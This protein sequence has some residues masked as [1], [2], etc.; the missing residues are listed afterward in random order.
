MTNILSVSHSPDIPPAHHLLAMMFGT[1]Q[2]QLIRVAAQLRIADL[3]KDGPKSIAT[4]A[5]ATCTDASALARVMRALTALGLV[6]ETETDQFTCTPVGELLRSDT[7][8]S[9]RSYTLLVGSEWLTRPWPNLLQGVQTGTS[10]F[11]QVFGAPLYEYLQYHPDAAAVFNDALTSISQQEA[12]ALREV[13]DFSAVRTLVDVGGGRGFLLATLLQAYPSLHGMLLDLPSVVAGAQALL[14]SE[15]DSG[16]C[17]LSSGDFFLA[18]PPGGDVY[19]LK[20]ILPAF[21]D[22]QALTILRNCRDAMT[23]NSHI[24]VADPDTSSLYGRLFDIAMLGIFDGR[25]RT[26]A[27]LRELFTGAGLTLTRTI[28]TRSMLRLVEG[29]PIERLYDGG[30]GMK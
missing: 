28:T 22:T 16:R 11:E 6:L 21:N 13:Y 10:A 30:T 2:T 23:P 17:Q 18:V 8:D 1:V 24:L 7:P 12:L 19:L 9:L 29:R 3:L 26:D 27:E 15:I 5:E 4:L 20:R 25:L 14:K